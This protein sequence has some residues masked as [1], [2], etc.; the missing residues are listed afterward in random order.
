MCSPHPWTP[1]S[2]SS[3]NPDAMGRVIMPEVFHPADLSKCSCYPKFSQKVFPLTIRTPRMSGGTSALNAKSQVFCSHSSAL[4]ILQYQG[5]QVLWC[6]S[7][8]VTSKVFVPMAL[9]VQ[10]SLSCLWVKDYSCHS[11]GGEQAQTDY[12]SRQRHTKN[13]VAL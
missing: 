4:H 3:R 8:S 10:S 6:Y 12:M 2:H 11:V 1:A 9:K 13:T 7:W 5:F